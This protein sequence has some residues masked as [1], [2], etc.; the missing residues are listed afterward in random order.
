M[1]ATTLEILARLLAFET[2]S[3]RS[4]QALISY[5]Q[6]NLASVGVASTLIPSEDGTRANLY[7]TIGPADAPGVMLSGHTDVVPVEGQA[8]T[9]SPFEMTVEDGLVY[10]RGSADMKGFVACALAAALKAANRPLKTPLHL[11][12]SYDEEI[13]CVGVRSMIEKLA[14]APTR[15]LFCIVGEPTS[16]AVATGHKGKTGF[17]M[18]CRGREAHSALAPT[19]Q[20]A[21]HLASDMIGAIPEAPG[22]DRRGGSSRR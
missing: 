21:I 18:I 4:N 11:A 7:A 17:R 13:G 2:I 9:K 12:F 19:G 3:R 1:T 10:G 5:I 20:N 6:E 22:G 8:W 15:P 16:M 14:Q